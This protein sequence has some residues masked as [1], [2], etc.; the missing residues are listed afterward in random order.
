[1]VVVPRKQRDTTAGLF[2]VYTH[3]VWAA[4]ALFRD[5]AD[6]LTF[7]RE[8]ARATARVEWTCVAYCLMTTHYHLILDVLDGALPKGMHALNFRYACGF[9]QRHASLGHVQAA[10]YG[11]RRI[12]GDEDMMWTYRYVARNPVEANLCVTPLDWPWSSYAAAAG[13]A[14]PQSFVDP[15]LALRC[16]GDT[17]DT[18]IAAMRA[19]VEEP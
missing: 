10:R 14:E 3:C 8:L 12:E 13:L 9:N 16:F 18:A 7:L 11:S 15:S 1:V 5:N 2:H 4:P 19:Y 6:R 17:R